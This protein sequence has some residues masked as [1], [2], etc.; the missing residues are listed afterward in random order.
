MGLWQETIESSNF[1]QA[2]ALIGALCCYSAR[3]ADSFGSV[4]SFVVR[5]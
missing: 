2:G 4:Q 1:S 5:S 3:Q